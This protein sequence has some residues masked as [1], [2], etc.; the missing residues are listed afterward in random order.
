M[1]TRRSAA[2][3][4]PMLTGAAC[5]RRSVGRPANEDSMADESEHVDGDLQD[6]RS[7]EGM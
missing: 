1:L 3:C 7:T 5:G 2:A 6:E 4:G